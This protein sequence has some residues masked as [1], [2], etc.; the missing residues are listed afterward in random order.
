MT[1]PVDS[2]TDFPAASDSAYLPQ[3]PVSRRST[4]LLAVAAVLAFATPFVPDRLWVYRQ[5]IGGIV[6]TEIIA[7]VYLSICYPPNTFNRGIYCQRYSATC[8][9]YSAKL[10][11][12]PE[13]GLIYA[14]LAFAVVALVV[15]IVAAA[16][17]GRASAV[18]QTALYRKL[19]LG[20]TVVNLVVLGALIIMTVSSFG[21]WAKDVH[22]YTFPVAIDVNVPAPFVGFFLPFVSVALA[23]VALRSLR[24]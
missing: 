3:S 4:I 5:T 23:A 6:W 19:A 9:Q 13:C 14:Q 17:A 16:F 21:L 22:D 24:R 10:A 11:S 20:A 18:R 2:K 1:Y 15:G 8:Y 7:N 12:F